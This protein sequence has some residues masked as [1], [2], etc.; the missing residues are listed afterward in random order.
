[1]NWFWYAVGALVV[2]PACIAHARYQYRRWVRRHS[3]VA[4]VTI[5][6]WESDR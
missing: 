6:N 3:Y 1:V 4:T 2:I 5:M